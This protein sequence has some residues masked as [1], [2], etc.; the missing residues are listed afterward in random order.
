[1]ST[2]NRNVRVTYPDN[3][4]EILEID[5][6]QGMEVCL[7]LP[8][9]ELRHY[10]RDGTV[11]IQQN[12]FALPGYRKFIQSKVAKIYPRDGEFPNNG[13]SSDNKITLDVVMRW[14]PGK[15]DESLDNEE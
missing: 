1:M 3:T 10:L 5:V 4:D 14:I 2:R 6:I 9:A 12:V 15:D 7:I 8:F 13:M 11:K